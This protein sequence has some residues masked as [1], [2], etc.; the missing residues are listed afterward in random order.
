MP[1]LEVGRVVKPHGLGGEV[2]VELVTNRDERVAPGSVL[3][4]AGGDLEVVGSRPFSATGVG[5]WIVTFR[6]VSDRAASECAE[7]SGPG[8]STGTRMGAIKT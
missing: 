6:G 7:A 5:R 2:V 4:T 3:H 8:C 1:L